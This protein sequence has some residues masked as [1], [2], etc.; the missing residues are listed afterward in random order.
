LHAERNEQ[1]GVKQRE[2]PRERRAGLE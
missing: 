1:R 2:P